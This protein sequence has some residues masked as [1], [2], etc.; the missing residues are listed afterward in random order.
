MGMINLVWPILSVILISLL[1]FVGVLSLV[2]S[3]KLLDK[4]L[5]FFVSFSAG[6]MIAGA[7]F[8]ILPESLEKT[9]SSLTVFFWTIVGFC[10]F[11]VL[12]RVLRWH[13]CHQ[14]ECETHK[15]LGWLNLFGDGLHNLLDGMIV[16][17]AFL[18]GPVLGIPVVLAIILHEIPQELGDFGVLLY[19]GFSKKKALLYNFFSALL[20]LAGVF[21]AYLLFLADFSIEGILL[22]LAAG[23]F[24]YVAASDLIPE[25][26]KEEKLGKAIWS[27]AFFVLALLMLLGLKLALE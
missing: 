19:S 1:S 22:P 13:H 4:I 18:S 24:I 2:F 17:A 5:I 9:Q 20:A 27:F 21:L 10:L 25:L 14:E 15:H 23:S 12:E 3:Y 8:H 26:H 11:F 6:G 16:F 7:F